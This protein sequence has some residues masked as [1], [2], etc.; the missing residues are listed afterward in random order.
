MPTCFLDGLLPLNACLPVPLCVL[1]LPV[2][3]GALACLLA[4]LLACRFAAT[5]RRLLDCCYRLVCEF[6]RLL[7][8]DCYTDWLCCCFILLPRCCIGAVTLVIV[9]SAA[10]ILMAYLFFPCLTCLP[11][12]LLARLLECRRPCILTWVCA[13]L[14]HSPLPCLLTCLHACLLA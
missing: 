12:C 4:C 2:C 5:Y 14:T 3:P 9:G 8:V 10:A 13:C 6:A 1:T 7:L 11:G